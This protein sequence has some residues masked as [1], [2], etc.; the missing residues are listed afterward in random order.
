MEGRH[1][2]LQ[3]APGQEH[4]LVVSWLVLLCQRSSRANVVETCDDVF[5]CC[6]GCFGLA[7]AASTLWSG[8]HSKGLLCH[9]FSTCCI[10]YSLESNL[11]SYFVLLEFMTW[12]LML[13]PILG[14]PNSPSITLQCIRALFASLN[15]IRF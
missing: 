12:L 1:P 13:Y 10:S 11:Q 4:G 9:W 2:R 6:R 8:V 14:F 7:S 5:S 3:E 15:L